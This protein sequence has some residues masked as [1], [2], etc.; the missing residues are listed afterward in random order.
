MFNEPEPEKEIGP[1]D[2]LIDEKRPRLYRNVKNY[3]SFNFECF[4]KELVPL[5][6]EKT[7]FSILIVFISSAFPAEGEDSISRSELIELN[8]WAYAIEALFFIFKTG[9]EHF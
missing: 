5:E 4:Q 1:V 6:S 2:G 9:L 7:W 8:V 3:A